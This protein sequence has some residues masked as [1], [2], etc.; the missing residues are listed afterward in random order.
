MLIAIVP[1]ETVTAATTTVDTAAEA[2]TR[3]MAAGSDTMKVIRTMIH[4]ANEGISL[5]DY[6]IGLLVGPFHFPSF[7]SANQGKP[8][9]TYICH[10]S[11]YYKQH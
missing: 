4:A 6:H 3:I 8:S 1:E 5:Q 7:K 9:T 2:E 10:F 11:T